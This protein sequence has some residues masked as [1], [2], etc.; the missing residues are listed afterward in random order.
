MN[1][2]RPIVIAL[3]G[4]ALIDPDKPPTVDNQTLVA[5]RVVR[6]IAELISRGERVVITH[7][8][9]PQVG[10]M[11]LR[12]EVGRDVVH[13]VP[14]DALVANTQGSLGYLMQRALREALSLRGMNMPVISVLT[15]VE[16]DPDDEAF[17]APTKPIGGFYT[18]LEAKL[19][20]SERGWT[21]IEDAHRGYRQVVASP[22]PTSIV[23]IE[24]IKALSATG[25]VVICCGG[26]GIPVVRA[27]DGSL[28]GVIG[29]IDK[30]RTSALLSVAINASQ[31]FLTTAVDRVYANFGTPEQ[32]PLGKLTVE[33]ALALIDT[34]ELPAGSMGPKV[35]SATRF[36]VHG[37]QQAVIC[38]PSSLV[39][40]FEGREGTRICAAE[41]SDGLG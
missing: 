34:G 2:K 18:A 23:Q 26:G 9:G 32:R 5:E 31:L 38:H 21:M 22:T 14:L 33:E 7:G 35:K 17:G 3:G 13:E 40:A 8:N 28:R 27:S 11:A 30:D 24:T 19:L 12:S 20:A 15:E 37:G 1:S 39:A 4:N 6:P 41:S 16:V 10:F 36:I 25:T 29:V